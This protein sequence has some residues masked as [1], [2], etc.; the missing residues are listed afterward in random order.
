MNEINMSASDILTHMRKG[1]E[2]YRSFG[3]NVELRMTDGNAVLVPIEIFD[4]LVGEYW[5]KPR[6]ETGFYDLA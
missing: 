3:E 2:L 1:A 6:G 5:I 4:S